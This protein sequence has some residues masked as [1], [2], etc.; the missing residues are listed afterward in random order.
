[1]VTKYMCS[2]MFVGCT[3]AD[4]TTL[5]YVTVGIDLLKRHLYKYVTVGI[6]SQLIHNKLIIA[7]EFI[8]L[9]E[10]VSISVVSYIV[11]SSNQLAARVIINDLLTYLFA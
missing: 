6:P 11:Q 4:R 5:K 1:M 3:Q 8:P 9:W 7:A 2:V 10:K